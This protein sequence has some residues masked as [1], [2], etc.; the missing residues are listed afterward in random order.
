MLAKEFMGL[1]AGLERA[2]GT[3]AID[4]SRSD[5]KQV[6]KAATLAKPVTLELWEEHLA[7]KRSLGIIPIRDDNQCVFG[8]IDIDIYQ[9]FNLVGIAKKIEKLDL[10][11]VT[12]RSKSGGA[13]LY[14]FTEEPVPASL[15]Q[16]KLREIAAAMGYGGSEIF[17]KQIE[18]ISNRGDIGQWINMPYF[19]SGR[20][21]RYCV[22]AGGKTLNA[23]EFL[24]YV[25][26]FRILADDLES[27]HVDIAQA[28]D[29]GPP[30]LQHLITQGFPEGVR[31]NGLFNL[32]VYARKAFPDTWKT[33]LEE[34]NHKYM[35]PPLESAEVQALAKSLARK[36]FR[37]TCDK[38]PISA[39]CNSAVCRLR[40]F[41]IGGSDNVPL[42]HSL[43]KFDS[44]P[45]IWFIDIE[46]QGRL[47]LSTEDLQNQGKFQKRCMDELNMMPQQMGRQA[48]TETINSLFENMTV[49]DVPEDA[50]LVGQLWLHL[51]AFCTGRAQAREP[52]EMLL[53]KPWYDDGR[54]VHWFRIVDFMKYLDR[55]H[56]REFKVHQIVAKL[57]EKGATHKFMK[58]KGRGVNCWGV[59]WFMQSHDTYKVPGDVEDDKPVF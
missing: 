31:N 24:E 52:E 3:Y 16:G 53:G 55:N 58:L 57:K 43:T 23:A 30:C 11:L 29:D 48:W 41:G 26:D 15:M 9:G 19:D 50:S 45:P 38:P 2:H 6:G 1:F 54:D 17:P 20:S 5:G 14:L 25:K 40:K 13:H 28:L 10:P 49:V 32:G 44:R 39:H 33:K 47:E 35:D 22:T 27:I 59:D 56:Y 42:M 34:Y 8:A 4:S 7:G 37:Y 51:E 36:D 12:I 46:G 21:A 18:I